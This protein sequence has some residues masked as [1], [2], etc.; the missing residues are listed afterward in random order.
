MDQRN[1]DITAA[2]VTKMKPQ[3]SNSVSLA[4]GKQWF[5]LKK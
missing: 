2:S 4:T 3:K 1:P 5:Q